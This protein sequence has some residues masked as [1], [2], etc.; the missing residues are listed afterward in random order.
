M[1]VG[2]INEPLNNLSLVVVFHLFFSFYSNKNSASKIKNQSKLERKN[3][4]Q[5]LLHNEFHHLGSSVLLSNSHFLR[6]HQIQNKDR[7]KRY[8]FTLTERKQYIYGYHLPTP[9]APDHSKVILAS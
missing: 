8:K 4:A 9:P 7:I 1:Q 5:C 3:L 6:V 2:L